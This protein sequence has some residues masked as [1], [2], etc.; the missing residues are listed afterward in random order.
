[1]HEADSRLLRHRL[2]KRSECTRI[3]PCN[4]PRKFRVILRAAREEE[5]V[6]AIEVR[7]HHGRIARVFGSRE[8]LAV[9]MRVLPVFAQLRIRIKNRTQ[10]LRLAVNR[11][12]RKP[13][14]C[15]DVSIA[16]PIRIEI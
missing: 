7:K 8:A 1:M 15:A 13:G 16:P 4:R 9:R 3:K 10:I 12:L 5:R 14:R 2:R 11:I 6:H